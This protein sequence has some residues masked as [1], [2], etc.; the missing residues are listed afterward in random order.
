MVTR[1]ATKH[2]IPLERERFAVVPSCSTLSTARWCHHKMLDL[3]LKIWSYNPYEIGC[4][5]VCHWSTLVC[6]NVKISFFVSKGD[7]IHRSSYSMAWQNTPRV[8]YGMP[9]LNPITECG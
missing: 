6:Q 9:N 8:P 1:Y 2:L 3:E 5:S 7:F 4:E